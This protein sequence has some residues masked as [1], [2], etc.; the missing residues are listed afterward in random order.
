MSIFIVE[1][2]TNVT[3][4]QSITVEAIDELDALDKSWNILEWEWTETKDLEQI[5]HNTVRKC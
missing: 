4:L 2:I 3:K 5:L 1:R